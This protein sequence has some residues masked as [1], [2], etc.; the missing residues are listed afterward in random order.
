MATFMTT[1]GEL[2][3]GMGP[4]NRTTWG[5]KI[6]VVDPGRPLSFGFWG[7]DPQKV[8]ETQPSVRKVVDFTARAVAAVAW[9]GFHR[10]SD[11]D[12]QRLAG[13]RVEKTLRQPS[14]LVTGFRLMHDLVVDWM[15]YDRCCAVLAS[16]GEIVR[17]PPRLLDVGSD[18]LGR[19]N[20]LWMSTPT[21]RVNLLDLPVVYVSGW[22]ASEAYGTS[23]LK[24]LR[25]LLDEQ[26]RA[27]QWR[28]DQW[29]RGA[30]LTGVITHPGRFKSREAREE[31][32]AKFDEYRHSKAGGTPIFENGLDYKSIET[33]KPADAKDIEGR[34][35][36]DV[37]VCS[38]YH[39]P[40]ELVG[41]REGTFSSVAAFR[42]M[43][44]GPTLGP[45]LTEFNQ[46]FNQEIVPALAEQP[47]TYAELDREGAIA[48]SFVEEAAV[49]QTAVGAP[50]LTRAE[51]RS[52][53]NLPYLDGTD[54][55][56]TPMNVTHGGLAS[57]RDT[58]PPDTDP[59]VEPEPPAPSDE[60][61]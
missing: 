25:S 57:P 19:V 47:D 54:E 58:A 39:I 14:R 6:H 15:L 51:A 5:D 60:D 13:G 43:L 3:I 16:D 27:V 12:R 55:L 22:N 53:K 30:K 4:V 10:V 28:A 34:Q 33:L 44:Y 41:A 32:S 17:V 18:F 11:T 31:F 50:W 9:H 52:R 49:L 7:R 20:E 36:T 48:G 59:A 2:V 1:G 40:P 24:T 42:Q 37:E 8:W 46:A 21:G 56:I 45:V 38:F 23:S 35:L 26:E 29:E 61:L